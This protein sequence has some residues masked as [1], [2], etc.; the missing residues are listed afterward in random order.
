MADPRTEAYFQRLANVDS[1]PIKSLG[2]EQKVADFDGPMSEEARERTPLETF[3]SGALQG[4]EGIAAD[5]EYFKALANTVVGADERSV[6]DN[7]ASA[8]MYEENAATAT[9]DIASFE[10]FLEEP[11]VGGFFTQALK[12]SGQ[13]APSLITTVAGGGIGGV[14]TVLGKKGIGYTGKK[15]AERIGRDSIERTVKGTATPDEKDLANSLYSTFKKGALGGAFIAEYVPLSGQNVNEALEAGQELTREQALRAGMLG[16][17]QAVVGV[18]GEAAIVKL[19]GN[20]ARKRA[21]KEGSTFS[22]FAKQVATNTL[23]TG[24]IEAGTETVQE[25]LSVLNRMDLDPTYTTEDAQLRLAEAAFGGFMGGAPVGGGGTIIGRT[26]RAVADAGV[27]DATADVFDK[28]RRMMDEKRTKDIND[29]VDGEQFGDLMSG[30][31]MPESQADINAQLNAMTDNTSDK[32]AVWVAGDTPEYKSRRNRVT[33][34]TVNGKLAFSAYIP[35]RGTIVSTDKAIVQEVINSRASDSSLAIAL[36]YNE[37]KSDAAGSDTVVQALDKDGNVVSEEVTSQEGIP[38]A[39]E[40]ARKLSP[41]GGTVN[42]TTLD[43]ALESRKRKVESEKGP[44]IRDTDVDDTV[45]EMNEDDLFDAIELAKGSKFKSVTVT[46]PDGTRVKIGLADLTAAA[47][48][49]TQGKKRSPKNNDEAADVPDPLTS[50]VIED[51]DGYIIPLDRVINEGDG[52]QSP[53]LSADG[54]IIG[55]GQDHLAFAG[56][57]S[58]GLGLE[59]TGSYSGFMRQTNAIRFSAFEDASTGD[60]VVSIHTFEGQKLTQAQ[61]D[62]LRKINTARGGKVK[63]LFGASDTQANPNYEQLSLDDFLS[64]NNAATSAQSSDSALDTEPDQETDIENQEGVQTLEGEETV[65]GTYEPK[66]DRNQTFDNT[67]EAR[68]DYDATFGAQDW[69][70]AEIGEA[71]ESTLREAVRQQRAN[72]NAVVTIRKN[73]DGKFEVVRTAFDENLID[74]EDNSGKEKKV[75]RVTES[76]FLDRAIKIAKNSKFKNIVLVTPDGKR[77]K[78]N[79]ADLTRAGQRLSSAR[80]D[81]KFEGQ[82]PFEAARKGL[83]EIL[84][85]LRLE[86]Y[87]VVVSGESIFDIGDQPVPDYQGSTTAAV[88]NGNQVTLGE[89]LS[90]PQTIPE[91]RPETVIAEDVDSEGRPTGEI[92][93]SQSGTDAAMDAFER[94]QRDV[95]GRETRRV[96]QEFDPDDQ[97]DETDGRSEVDRNLDQPETTQDA[98]RQ[99]DRRTGRAPTTNNQAEPTQPNRPQPAP[100]VVAGVEES[101]LVGLI[102]N[103]RKAIKL[104]NPPRVFTY[105]KLVNMTMGEI[106]QQF[107]AENVNQVL[108]S[109]N[110]MRESNGKLRGMHVTLVDSGSEANLII[111]NESGNTLRDAAVLAHEFGHALFREEMAAA[112]ANPALRAR[113]LRAFEKDPRHQNYLNAY[114]YELAFEEWY[115]DQVARWATKK[116]INKQAK[117][118]T[119]KHFKELAQKL[120]VMYR[121]FT[122]TMKRRLGNTSQDFETYIEAVVDA[123]KKGYETAGTNTNPNFV[124]KALVQEVNQAVVKMGGEGLADHW[125]GTLAKIARNPKM[126]PLM[127]IVRTADGIMRLHGGRKIADMFYIRSQDS[128]ADGGLGFVGASARQIADFQNKFEEEV[129]SMDDPDVQAALLE[130]MGDEDTDQLSPKAQQV[131]KFLDTVYD[132]YIAPS[133]TDIGRRENYFPTAL[134]LMAIQENLDEFVQLV[135]EQDPTAKEEDV[136]KSINAVLKYN[137]SVA[138][139]EPIDIDGTNPAEAVEKAL[140]LTVNVGRNNLYQ[141]GFL[142]EP[143]DAFVQ[144]L[145][146]IVKRVE[147]NKHTK[148]ED[149]NS[150]LE[151]EMDKLD[152]EDKAVVE[153]IIATHLG[154]QTNPLSPMWRKVNSYGQFLQFI[155]ILPFAAIASL[156]ELAGPVINSKEFS[157]LIEGLKQIPATIKNRAEARQ[158]ARDLGVVTNEVVANSWVTQAELDYMDPKVRKMSDVFFK[159]TGLQWFTTFSREFA[160]GMGVQFILKHARNEFDNPRSERYLQELGLTAEDVLAWNKGGRKFTTPEGKKVKRGLQRFVESSILRPNSAER[161]VWASDPHWALVWQLKSYFYAYGKV[162]MGGVYREMVARRTEMDGQGMPQLTA[163]LAVLGLTALATMPLAMLAMEVREYTKQGLAA[164][165]PGVETDNKYFRTDRMDWPTY[166]TEVVD[167]SGF[168]GIFTLA[169]MSHQNAKW[170]DEGIEGFAPDSILPFLGPTAETVDTILENGFQVNKTLKDRLIP[171]Y[172]QL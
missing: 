160:A 22:D 100:E 69:S 5:V 2:T 165:L 98:D 6:A 50:S 136:R 32:K 4:A 77:I 60:Y 171:I 10:E 47:E 76:E 137:Q 55:T 33:N 166:L 129:G 150:I 113:L 63:L 90:P 42:V 110:R 27:L 7:I 30:N 133:N 106:E 40:N 117:T 142:H 31:T 169:A 89:L 51:A 73:S 124:Q 75:Y 114:D 139:G 156:P 145:R 20:V 28:A 45:R 161:P 94:F 107:G 17:P 99:T 26:A 168:L 93:G 16:V 163:T 153:E 159:Y 19:L 148:D 70:T 118:L 119:D 14:A 11:T 155:T 54:K 34:I 37:S 130:A 146:H 58:E 64:E 3:K 84:T 158:F 122:R 152:P 131:R 144:Y 57:A 43:E 103:L 149:G 12:F 96:N 101:F 59:N 74:L 13:A 83:Q 65:T 91:Q 87:D 66:A 25:G 23:K 85:E 88:I 108:S 29:T 35:G 143:Q 8:R 38:A 21:V 157:G 126:R 172:N 170:D 167:K 147:W 18:A 78:V 104:K 49:L 15:I 72:K 62:V 48:K 36:G 127:K 138:D 151:E 53:W 128:S 92:V 80:G 67:Q 46:R 140:K 52:F 95:M 56:N 135:I 123:K 134:N 61:L 121:E 79:L 39:L 109:I 164:I 41:K 86:G 111:L 112:T 9:E 82:T 24:A 102:N 1:D 81:G 120:K 97:V 132:E 105:E 154:Y 125:R 115:A 162:I 44:E 71:T 141:A 68:D 116:F